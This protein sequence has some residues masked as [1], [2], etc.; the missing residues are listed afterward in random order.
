MDKG[1][2]AR[3]RVG[4]AGRAHRWRITLALAALL[5]PLLAA[6][7]PAWTTPVTTVKPTSAASYPHPE[8]LADTGWLADRLNDRSIR[9]VDLSPLE[10]Y[11]RGH[12]PGAV[13]VWWQDLMEVHNGTY[14]MLID[15][16][17]RKRVFEAAGI[18][19]GMTVVA[20]DDAGGR[21]AA[22]FLWTLLYTDYAAGRLLDGGIAI[23][24]AEGR[25]ITRDVPTVAAAQLPDRAPHEKYLINGEDLL[26]DLGQPGLAVV[27]TRTL[28]EGRETWSGELRF[29]R[30][31]GARSIPWDRNLAQKNTAIVRDPS[32][33]D[34]VYSGQSLTRDQQIVVYGLTGV[35]A[36]HT[37]WMLRVL[38]YT[39]VR[40]Y[41]GSWA[42]WGANA[43]NTPYTI[44][45]LAVGAAPEDAPTA[46]GAHPSAP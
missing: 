17:G 8:Y 2:N 7:G 14:G 4:T 42:E 37:F 24:Q 22:R 36:T 5:V 26:R 12:L 35:D 43:P 11:E 41:D 34:R 3:A 29:G 28:A 45:P 23:W 21:Y 31:P 27:D 6:C 20:Y 18:A 44:E 25:T 10:D 46:R 16:A 33:L 1:N 39:N 40:L 30:I 32:E 15:P 9:I 19:E 38:G 13:H